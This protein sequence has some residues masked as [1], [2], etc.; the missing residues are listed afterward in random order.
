[1]KYNKFELSVYFT[2]HN[3]N[4]IKDINT[5][6]KDFAEMEKHLKIGK[7]YLET[8]RVDEWVEKEKILKLKEFFQKKGI[9]VAGGITTARLSEGRWKLFCY[10]SEEELKLL[11][12]IIRFTAP[13]FDEIILDD[14]FF[15]NCR[16]DSC[17]KAK[18]KKS[19]SEYRTELLA[20]I[21]ERYIVKP[22][23][24]VNPNIKMVIKFP[25][26]YEYYHEAGYNLEKEP[27]IFDGIYT[28]TET[29]DTIYT[30]QNLPRYLSYFLMRYLE[31]VKPGSNG[32]GWFDSFDC[33]NPLHYIEQGYLTLFA[34][35]REVTLFCYGL[36][37]D[38]IYVP[39]AGYA[40]EKLDKILPDIGN[41]VGVACYRPFHSSGEEYL[42]NVIGM[43][44]IPLE[45]YAEYPSESSTI[46]L[47]AS[48]GNDPEIIDKL[49]KSLK[50]GKTVIVTSGF[51]KKASDKF[52]KKIASVHP[53]N[54]T[55]PVSHFARDIWH[56]A[57]KDY[58]DSSVPIT[59][60]AM[61]YPTNDIWPVVVGMVGESS[62][63]VLLSMSYGE[64]RLLIL[65]I[66]VSFSDL[67][68]LPELALNRIRSEILSGFP[69]LIEGS[70]KIGL[71]LYDNHTFIVESFLPHPT[72]IKL[73]LP[74]IKTIEN[75]KTGE[76]LSSSNGK[77]EIGI[78]PGDYLIFKY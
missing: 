3:I 13:I 62:V 18:G 61:E 65:N 71:F 46:L 48:A 19:W 4:A 59:L 72:V 11:E 69:V 73:V 54:K 39:V 15:T 38:T 32:G 43:L 1:M 40:F 42:H 35:A 55:V 50:E 12:K 7:V 17:T 64:G 31:N 70:A 44:G 20:E 5:F 41:P 76:K 74:K 47:T 60:P 14:F 51:I 36:I 23:K 27:Y 9:T 8:Y 37:R 21:S 67:Y 33:Y 45:P 78:D 26:W 57:Y 49:E 77:F 75:L 63:P 68:H 16:C 24:E 10:S 56:C 28:G 22:A 53:L 2:S 58:K 52:N 25:N 6:E 34:K 30:Q 66:P 29:R